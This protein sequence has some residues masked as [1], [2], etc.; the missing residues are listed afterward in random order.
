MKYF[1]YGS[2]LCTGKLRRITPSATKIAVA[3]LEAYRL[4]FHKKSTDASAKADAFYTG[5]WNDCVWGVV[6]ELKEAEKSKLDDE[7]KGY[8]ESILTVVDVNGVGYPV[9]V[10]LA[11][12]KEI[13][14]SLRPYS[15]YH[16][17][18]I[19][20]ARQH[21]LPRDYIQGYIETVISIEDPKPERDAKKRAIEC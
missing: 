2:N 20:G 21:G 12:A 6:F 18:V 14:S 19:E 17:F 10:Y 1:A 9:H 5:G 15:W 8:N 16:R 3:K 7:E 11:E 13:D 4:C